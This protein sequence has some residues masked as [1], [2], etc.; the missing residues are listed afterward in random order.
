M[1][2]GVFALIPKENQ[3]PETRRKPHK[4]DEQQQQQQQSV[5]LKKQ[6]TLTFK[7][8]RKILV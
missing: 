1:K 7:K 5:E 6:I 2:N 8:R 3:V 4:E